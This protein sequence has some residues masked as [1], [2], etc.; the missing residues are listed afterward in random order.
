M[1]RGSGSGQ[2]TH[3]TGPN[4]AQYAAITNNHD[5]AYSTGD[6]R[7]YV[8]LAKTGRVITLGGVRGEASTSQHVMGASA[9]SFYG[10]TY[11]SAQTRAL[12]WQVSPTSVGPLLGS[13]VSNLVSVAGVGLNGAVAGTPW[14]SGTSPDETYR[15]LV[16]NGGVWRLA[17]QYKMPFG[18]EP[19]VAVSP[20][21]V[22]VYT[23]TD[24]L[25]HTYTCHR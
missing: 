24:H 3:L 23:G 22:V 12:R 8:R 9:T 2:A 20:T 13:K 4:G 15:N 16:A 21:G 10:V 7:G 19:P 5:L 1:W 18:A 25:P 17:P 11:G 14:I 6:A